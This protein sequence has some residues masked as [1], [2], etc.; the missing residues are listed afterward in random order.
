MQMSNENGYLVL[1]RKA[2]QD[3]HFHVKDSDGSTTKF[4]IAFDEGLGSHQTKLS[5][6]APQSVN[7][8][9]GELLET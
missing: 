3:L 1:T 5:I 8:I 2:G 7:V 6:T 4:H 9:R